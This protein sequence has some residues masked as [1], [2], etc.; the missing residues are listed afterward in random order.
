MNGHAA[1]AEDSRGLQHSRTLALESPAVRSN[2]FFIP[3]EVFGVPVFGFGLLLAV[4][5]VF[6]LGM[7]VWLWW[8]QGF[9]ADTWSYVPL[10]AVV[11]AILWWVLPAVC[12]PRGL[13]IRGWGTMVVVATVAATGLTLWRARRRG[14]D[15]ELVLSLVFWLFLPGV[16]G[17]R[18]FYVIEYWPAQ[19]S[20]VY[21]EHGLRALLGEVANMAEGGMVVYGAVLGGT[22]GL[23]AFVRR[24]RLAMLPICDLIAPGLVL[25]VAF[26]RIGCLLNGCCFGSVCDL[27]WAVTFPFNGASHVHQVQHGQTPVY[28]LKIAGGP[29]ELPVIT[30]VEPGSP[31]AEHG[32]RPKQRIA[33]VNGIAIDV[34]GVDKV[35]RAQWALLNAHRLH[36]L[37]ARTDGRQ[38]RWTLD[39]LPLGGP[40]Y[41]LAQQQL[42]LLGLRIDGEGAERPIL[43]AV[44]S[45]SP[46]AREG[47][48]AGDRIV[49]VNGRP[50]PSIGDFVS[51][52]D[53]H[54]AAPWLAIKTTEA[55][56]PAEWPIHVPLPRSRRVHPT[57]I[58]SSVNA[59]LMCLLLLAYDPLRRRDG[60]LFALMILLYP[61]TRFL[62]EIIRTDESAVFGTGLSISQNVSLGLLAF[63]VGLWYYIL[64]QPRRSVRASG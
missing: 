53:E 34:A 31:A 29:D 58:Y 44:R 7:L 49:G 57:Q 21:A 54:K 17:A 8:R 2:L 32:L 26:G 5:V 56:T 19:Y 16:V 47:L 52:L 61:I 38:T 39:D 45:G 64:R 9:S 13:P 18:A 60:E 30:H 1:L 6:C 33:E 3:L 37:I 63:A 27:P 46:A 14:I 36:V 10:L 55:S 35:R 28:G 41:R 23:L 59:L 25:G 48:Q 22:L 20:P 15:P 50:V 43:A 4:W 51:R 40:I 24:Y 62:L 12:Q 42:Y 11:G